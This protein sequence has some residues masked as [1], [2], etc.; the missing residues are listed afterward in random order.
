TSA[1]VNNKQRR[2]AARRHLQ[3][4]LER[5]QAAEQ[6]RKKATQLIAGIVGLAVVAAAIIVTL[7]V[8]GGGDDDSPA[9][10]GATCAYTA[11][12]TAAK[13]ATLPPTTGVAN[14]G[15]TKVVIQTNNG[16]VDATLD[17]ANAPCA[18]NSF[19]S[20]ASQGYFDS[21][22]CHRLTTSGILVLQ[23]GDPGGTGSGGP[24]YSF[25]DELTGSEKYTS[26]V[27]AMANSGA[28]TNGSQF[29]LVYGDS[30]GLPASYTIL[31]TMDA[32]GVAV[33]QA[34]AAAGVT[35]GGSDGEPAR[36]TTIETVTVGDSAS[37]GST[38]AETVTSPA[39]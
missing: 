17:R 2:E 38:N 36:P 24:G 33:V 9:A 3:R 6:R 35:G 14:T 1:V 26:G 4:Q 8:T 39:S 16:T 19:V 10:G 37:A 11:G 27:I 21:T 22:P 12:G 18:V 29:F 7:V 31:G 5:R 25:A 32:A 13:K 20:L 28:N 30:T 34:I 15:T 23:C